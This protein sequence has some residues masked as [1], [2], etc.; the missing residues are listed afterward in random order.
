MSWAQNNP[1]Y[2]SSVFWGGRICYPS[3]FHW[4]CICAHTHTQN[5]FMEA[6]TWGVLDCSFKTIQGSYQILLII[7]P[8]LSRP[9]KNWSVP[10]VWRRETLKLEEQIPWV[11]LLSV[12]FSKCQQSEE[13][14]YC[15]YTTAHHYT[16]SAFS[17]P[18][19]ASSGSSSF[20]K[21]LTFGVPPGSFLGPGHYLLSFLCYLLQS[22][23]LPFHSGMQEC[24]KVNSK[25]PWTQMV[26]LNK[27]SLSVYK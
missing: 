24:A 27:E 1:A 3:T 17:L 4:E 20:P 6:V 19:V 2:R 5:P 11:A 14:V 13:K 18:S 22:C 23:D 26:P 21:T 10:Q 7:T 9:R 12:H 25:T 15:H 16:L 8:V